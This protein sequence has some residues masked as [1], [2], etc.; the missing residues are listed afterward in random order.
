MY[1]LLADA[2]V[3][4]PIATSVPGMTSVANGGPSNWIIGF[5]NFALLI[6]GILAFGS[7][8]Y[9]GVLYA[10]SSGNPERQ[11]KGQSWIQSALVG[12]LLLGSA[13]LILHI[14]NPNLTVLSNPF[15]GTST[16][17]STN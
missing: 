16:T 14:I 15:T 17:G 8:V 13:Y 1:N 6:S 12:L 9:G 11:H 10:L 4:Q 5:Y 3:L 2:V 7:I